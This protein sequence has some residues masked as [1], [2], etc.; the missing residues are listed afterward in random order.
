MTSTKRRLPLATLCSIVAVVGG[1]GTVS[2]AVITGRSSAD[3]LRGTSRADQIRAGAGNDTVLALGGADRI[4]GQGGRDRIVAGGGNDRA[5]GGPGND[6]LVGEGGNDRLSGDGGDD[7]IF[8]NA[9]ADDIRGGPGV[10]AMTGSEGNDR[11][12]G[13]P[14]TDVVQGGEGID[15]IDG[16]TGNDLVDS[17]DL[18]GESVTCGAG[19]DLV[20]ADTIDTGPA[21]DCE[22]LDRSDDPKRVVVVGF[23]ARNW[24][25]TALQL[26]AAWTKPGQSFS[27]CG[28]DT[29]K[30]WAFVMYRGIA[31]GERALVTWRVDRSI[32]NSVEVPIKNSGTG[33]DSFFTSF[34]DDR[35]L[36]N[37]LWEVEV[38]TQGVV[39]VRSGFTRAC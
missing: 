5:F 26:P 12:N 7:T 27:G 13:G 23:A 39:R 1:V 28:A 15:R 2:A 10:D 29:S 18:L 34:K 35:P 32:F 22:A 25:K 38:A 8:G 31:R 17:Y 19:Q 33:V 9:G 21:D 4:F 24:K 11:L 16:G 20:L 6:A 30:I 37:G 3:A 36:P 14:G